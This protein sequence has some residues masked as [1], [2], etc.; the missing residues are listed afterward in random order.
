MNREIAKFIVENCVQ[1]SQILAR[2]GAG[3]TVNV[4]DPLKDQVIIDLKTLDYYL[5]SLDT[6]RAYVNGAAIQYNRDGD[7]EWCGIDDPSFIAPFVYRVKPEP[8]EVQIVIDNNGN[9]RDAGNMNAYFPIYKD[10]TFKL[11]KVREVL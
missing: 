6:I 3:A 8:R 9:V 1:L 10:G 4:G 5:V 7:E 2:G 11:I